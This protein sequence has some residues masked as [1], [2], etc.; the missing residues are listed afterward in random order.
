MIKKLLLA[1]QFLTI[2]PVK[3]TLTADENDIAKSSSVFVIVGFIQGILLIAA[4]YVSGIFFH[5]DLVIAMV[6]LV[7]VLSN[8]GFHLDGLADTFDAI[9]VKS[10]GN[11]EK[12]KEKRLAVMKDSSTG[13]IGVLA[14]AFAL[15]LKYAALKNLSHFLPFT[16]YSSLLLMPVFSKW[17]MV[18]SMLHGKAARDN[19]LGKIFMSK[20]GFKEAAVSTLLLIVILILIQLLLSR[21]ALGNQH[22]FY[23]ML[24]GVLCFFCRVLVY[25][26]NK[27]FGGLTGD[28]LGAISELTE[29][30]FLFMVIIWLRLSI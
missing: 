27:R 30:A 7:L 18:V 21:Y 5:H 22:I 13:P 14:I 15:F 12:D 25:F 19:G 11:F 8:G 20:A 6:L 28:T 3:K 24:L 16:Y 29:I 10:S 17:A 2:I 23:A 4:D 26:F 9:A 1:F